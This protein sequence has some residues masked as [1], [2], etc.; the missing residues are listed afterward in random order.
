[1]NIVLGGLRAF[2]EA[3]KYAYSFS[4]TRS[5]DHEKRTLNPWNGL[6]IVSNDLMAP[7]NAEGRLG[8]F[9]RAEDAA[10]YYIAQQMFNISSAQLPV[11]Q[12]IVEVVNV[13]LGKTSSAGLNSKS[14]RLDTNDLRTGLM[15]PYAACFAAMHPNEL[16]NKHWLEQMFAS[17][18]SLPHLN[19]ALMKDKTG[20]RVIVEGISISPEAPAKYREK[21]AAFDAFFQSTTAAEPAAFLTVLQGFGKIELYGRCPRVVIVFTA[22]QDGLIPENLTRRLEEMV[23][24]LL[25]NLSQARIP[26]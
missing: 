26:Q 20:E 23:A 16:S 13:E 15:G 9:E 11:A 1:M 8:G 10:N 22:P 5:L 2:R 25:P 21:L 19:R 12:L 24:A 18:I 17:S 14:L 3:P 7:E 4:Y 6:C